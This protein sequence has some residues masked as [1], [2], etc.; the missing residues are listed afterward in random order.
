[1]VIQHNLSAANAYN[2]LN[3]NVA[4]LKVASERL[5]SGLRI[6]SAADDA[7]GLA[8]SEKMRSQIRG[9]SQAVRNSQDGINYI[10]TGEGAL[11]E[12]HTIL[13]RG[14]ELAEESANGT[15]ADSTDR[16]A[17]ENE[18]RQLCEEVDYISETDF[19]GHRIFDTGNDVV[20]EHP[21]HKG[22]ASMSS[23]QSDSSIVIL[24]CTESE[25]I[26][27]SIEREA[28]A[29]TIAGV[30]NTPGKNFTTAALTDF[31]NAVKNTYLP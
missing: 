12:I 19:N 30:V 4:G 5:S 16:S 9:L 6:N 23:V 20:R 3:T 28:L 1:M 29:D 27:I 31:S 13:Q 10:Q 18:W 22:S 2:K 11:G 24:Q 25:Y 7:A 26:P 15:Y 17:L 14:K 8:I 21:F